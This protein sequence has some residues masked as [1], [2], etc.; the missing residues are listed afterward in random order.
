MAACAYAALAGAGVATAAP[1]RPSATTGAVANIAPTS[2]T[3]LGSVR[4]N[5]LATSYN[6]Q[7]G[8]TTDYTA[9]TARVAAGRG[10]DRVPVAIDV[11]GLAPNTDYHYRIVARNRR[12]TV[13]GAD[14]TFRTRRQPLGFSLT[15]TPNPAPFGSSIVLSGALAGTRTAGKPVVLQANPFPFTQGFRR[16]GNP[17][18]VDSSGAFDFPVLALTQNTQYR[19]GV[20]DTTVLSPVVTAAA[21]VW[22][23][24]RLS[25]RRV[26]RGRTIRFSGA[27]RPRRDGVRLG[28]Q[29]L[30]SRRAWVTV[31]GTRTRSSGREGFSIFAKRVRIRRGGRYRVFVEITDG[32]L[33]S[34]AGSTVRVRSFRRR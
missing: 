19:V 31:A 4:P 28:I 8:P 7:Y 5:E 29:K 22:V 1:A 27:V 17:Q 3:L 10:D 24:T 18:V 13:P 26:R 21:A 25:T 15:A 11:A 2:A 14:R 34:A 20:A 16:V 23:R 33:A 6:F 9:A 30:N 12:G 32:S